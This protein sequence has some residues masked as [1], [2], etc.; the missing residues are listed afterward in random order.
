MASLRSLSFEQLLRRVPYE[1]RYLLDCQV[2]SDWHLAEIA[3]KVT[4]WNLVLPYL[5]VKDSVE[6]EEAI[7]GNYQT[8]ERRRLV[9][10]RVTESLNGFVFSLMKSVISVFLLIKFALCPSR[11]TSSIHGNS[12]K[13]ISKLHL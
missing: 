13:C 7:L 3:R 12:S 1:K 9:T 11:K 4:D 2:E 6:V 10:S 5:I 8:V